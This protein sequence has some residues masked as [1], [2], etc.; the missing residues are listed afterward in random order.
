[1][2]QVNGITDFLNQ[3]GTE[4]RVFDV[5]VSLNEQNFWLVGT[6]MIMRGRRELVGICLFHQYY[7]ACIVTEI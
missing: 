3:A 6:E 5:M 1:M 7:G 2:S 4:F